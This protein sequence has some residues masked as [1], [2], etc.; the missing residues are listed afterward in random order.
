MKFLSSSTSAFLLGF[1]LTAPLVSANSL[2]EKLPSNAFF[3]IGVSNYP[4]VE[5]RTQKSNLGKAWNSA[6][7]ASLKEGWIEVFN[8]MDTEMESQTGSKLSEF[9]EHFH[10][11]LVAYGTTPTLDALKEHPYVVAFEYDPEKLEA[12]RQNVDAAITKLEEK[13]TLTKTQYEFQGVAIRQITF[14]E[15]SVVEEWDDEASDFVEV[16][17]SKMV[18][19]EYSFLE[20]KNIF[21]FSYGA[22]NPAKSLVNSLQNETAE[23]LTQTASFQAYQ[24]LVSPK[25][26][27]IAF[28]QIDQLMQTLKSLPED[29]EDYNAEALR[30]FDLSGLGEIPAAGFQTSLVEG[31]MYSEYAVLVPRV[32][33]GILAALYPENP[34]SLSTATSVPKNAL[35]YNSFQFDFD[36]VWVA[37]TQL[38]SEMNP[39]SKVQ[40]D[41][42]LLMANAQTQTNIEN[43]LLKNIAGEH[44][45]YTIR[46]PKGAELSEQRSA[47]MGFT[48]PEQPIYAFS[49]NTRDA[50]LAHAAINSILDVSTTNFGMPYVK[51]DFN[52]VTIWEPNEESRQTSGPISMPGIA[53]LPGKIGIVMNEEET[54]ALIRRSTGMEKE[55]IVDNPDYQRVVSGINKEFL[56]VFGYNSPENLPF[57]MR[58]IEQELMAE[59]E[60]EEEMKFPSEQW[61]KNYF[62]PVY[63]TLYARP[64]GFYGNGLME[65][66][67]AQ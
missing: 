11:D 42:M 43:N 47:E 61:Y 33:K 65:F 12:L 24:N 39:E 21:F 54:R 14:E 55:S 8:E 59:F 4:E 34:V 62:G 3:A 10:G 22:N 52:S 44:F 66:V 31:G 25:Y 18:T 29:H 27:V 9:K 26:D 41:Q 45:S 37:I 67:P 63:N 19:L 5:E 56:M 30:F 49:I 36:R 6:E 15:V 20:E 28:M 64:E 53:L 50:Q 58:T 23:R 38:V 48:V 46:D 40:L 17:V 32:R 1:S 7:M 16:E 60:M 2:F 51:S 13:S 57:V 35:T